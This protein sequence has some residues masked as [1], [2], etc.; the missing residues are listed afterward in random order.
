MSS[1]LTCVE[2]IT[3]LW[4]LDLNQQNREEPWSLKLK[5]NIISTGNI[6]RNTSVTLV[7]ETRICSHCWNVYTKIWWCHSEPQQQWPQ[8]QPITSGGEQRFVLHFLKM[9]TQYQQCLRVF[10]FM[11]IVIQTIPD[12]ML[13]RFETSIMTVS[14]LVKTPC[15]IS[16][17]NN[18]SNISGSVPVMSQHSDCP[19][20]GPRSSP[21]LLL[22]TVF[23][24][25]F[26]AQSVKEFYEPE[27]G[28]SL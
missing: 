23:D 17:L 11:P 20:R 19:T 25:I 27:R 7:A 22:E 15:Q 6:S 16:T 4:I 26:K 13:H 12:Y 5:G 10:W 3:L 21:C 8:T 18:H 2:L 9:T 24:T 28:V 14:I 1:S